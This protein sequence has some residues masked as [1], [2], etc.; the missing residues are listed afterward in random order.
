M[1]IQQSLKMIQMKLMI[2]C[3]DCRNLIGLVIRHSRDVIGRHN[4]QY[5]T[6]QQV[7]MCHRLVEH[8]RLVLGY[9]RI[10]LVSNSFVVL[11]E[12]SHLVVVLH[13]RCRLGRRT[14]MVLV[15]YKAWFLD[16]FQ[17]IDNESFDVPPSHVI[18]SHLVFLLV[19]H[20]HQSLL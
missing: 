16:R 11:G 17:Q 5:E 13:V 7:M 10:P 18:D 19:V 3:T 20:F 9:F 2:G 1:P 4:H 12:R 8:Y 15:Q 14:G 6:T